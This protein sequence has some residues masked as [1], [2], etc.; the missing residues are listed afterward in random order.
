MRPVHRPSRLVRPQAGTP[1]EIDLNR[2]VAA[3]DR[4]PAQP[5]GRRRR[6]D[7][8]EQSAATS[9]TAGCTRRAP[10]TSPR[11]R[12]RW[13][14]SPRPAARCIP[15]TCTA[16]SSG[17]RSP[18]APRSSIDVD[19]DA[20][21]KGEAQDLDAP[22]RRRRLGAGL[23]GE[24]GALLRVLVP[25]QRGPRRRGPVVLGVLT[26]DGSTS[27]LQALPPGAFVVVPGRGR[28]FPALHARARVP[29]ARDARDAA[30]A[31]AARGGPG[32]SRAWP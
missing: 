8:R 9:S 32:R 30:A 20:V 24:D 28:D 15:P 5:A 16:S 11:E 7:R 1:I 27:S 25:H 21:R 18:A 29:A 10:T 6:C 4:E 2:A 12:P 31:L 19:V 14:A 23:D 13:A 26:C 22:G 3:A 17:A